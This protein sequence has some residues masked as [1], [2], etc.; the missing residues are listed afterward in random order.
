M[1]AP[2]QHAATQVYTQRHAEINRRGLSRVS[3]SRHAESHTRRAR[4]QDSRRSAH[5]RVSWCSAKNWTN[6]QLTPWRS[7]AAHRCPSATRTKSSA[8]RHW[9]PPSLVVAPLV[10]APLPAL[11]ATRRHRPLLV[12]GATGA[13]PL[14][15][16][17]VHQGATL[18]TG[19]CPANKCTP[20]CREYA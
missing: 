3:L 11:L 9:A 2:V 20:P 4:V 16:L 13:T 8:A 15:P 14:G 6:K 18:A 5:S 10:A 19:R 7:Y 1:T 17:L 12:L